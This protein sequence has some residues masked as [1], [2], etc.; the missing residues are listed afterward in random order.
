MKVRQ[1]RL[2]DQVRDIIAGCF[3]GGNMEDPRL[4]SVTIT[5]VS[6]TGDLQI[7]KVYFRLF[8][9]EPSLIEKAQKGLESASSY[10]RRKLSAG[11][12]VRRIPELRFYYD[13]TIEK[14]SRV[15]ELLSEI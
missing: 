1:M 11:L 15:D 2:A 13:G 10:F 14:A 8:D 6:L 12:A 5:A 4:S 9:A 7:A 3:L